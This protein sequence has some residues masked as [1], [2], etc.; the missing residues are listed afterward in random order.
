MPYV[1]GDGR[2][3]PRR[4]PECPALMVA[5]LTPD[6]DPPLSR[7]QTAARRLSDRL[8]TAV[9]PIRVVDAV[10]WDASVG[11]AFLAA[12]GRKLPD[13]TATSYRPLSFDPAVK[14]QELRR[15]ESDA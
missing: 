1:S 6:D 10:R 7:E 9:R 2:G 8:V 12:G 3:G 14:C 13:I 11:D 5:P 15:I 4:P